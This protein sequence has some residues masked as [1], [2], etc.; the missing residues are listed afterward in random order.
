MRTYVRVREATI[1][2]ADLDAF[3]A[4]VEQRDDPRLRG[5][6][7]DRRRRASCSRPATRRRRTASARRWA[8]AQARR[9]CPHAIVVPPRMSAYSEASKAVFE[10]FER[11]DA[12]RRGAVD[13]RGVPRRPRAASASRARRRDRGAAAAR[14][15]RA[16]RPADHRRRG[17]D[18][19]PRQGGERRGQARR[20]A[21]RAARRR[22]RLPP[23]A[24]GR[25]AVGRR[26][27]HRREAPRAR[28]HDRRRGRGAR[29]GGARRAC[30]AARRA[31]TSTRSPTTAIRGRCRSA[32]GG[33]SIGAQR[34][35]GRRAPRSP[36]DARRVARSGSSTGVTRR[37][38]GGRPRRAAP[39]CCGCASTT[40]RA[41]PA[42]TRCRGRPPTR[43]RSSPRRAGCS[44]AAMPLIERRGSR[45]SASRVGNLEDDRAVQ[46]ALPF[47]RQSATRSTPRST[48]CATGSART[49]VTRAVLLGR[50]EL[51]PSMPLLHRQLR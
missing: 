7:V 46:L 47:D 44:P 6:P 22:A 42:R 14:G 25:A 18:E 45:S 15:A 40:S 50:R 36:D 11:H 12:A 5:R 33:G 21:G 10:V 29:R 43:R 39:S 3:F 37:L 16:G 20:A 1:L 48:R 30:S 28:D 26:R 51:R 24:P 17:A 2:H 31:G 23:P 13:R 8:G 34:A 27:G 19:V 41:R 4:S 32:A 49:R 35:L 38:R 9:L